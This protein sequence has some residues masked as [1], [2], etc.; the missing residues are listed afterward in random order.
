MTKMISTK[1]TEVASAIEATNKQLA[2]VNAK[3]GVLQLARQDEGETEADRASAISQAAAEQ[4]AL[5]VSGKL[6]EELLSK[7][8][9]TAANV[10][11]DQGGTRNIFGN[12]GKGF[13]IGTSHGQI[14]GNF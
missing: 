3:L 14:T 5:D 8:K 12:Q 11:R 7:T 9:A 2:E 1:E 6:L 4:T 10:T 13:M